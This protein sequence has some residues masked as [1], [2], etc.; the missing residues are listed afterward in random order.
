MQIP[1]RFKPEVQLVEMAIERFVHRGYKQKADLTIEDPGAA[2]L[3]AE[4]AALL[5]KYSSSL[6]PFTP[7]LI[8]FP[9]FQLVPTPIY[10][11]KHSFRTT[12]ML[13][14]TFQSLRG[15][16]DHEDSRIS[17]PIDDEVRIQYQIHNPIL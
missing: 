7:S 3:T 13:I 16:P 17:T 10:Q 9:R 14:D 6:N 2:E 8:A 1:H 5:L 4:E 11:I 12:S 15:V